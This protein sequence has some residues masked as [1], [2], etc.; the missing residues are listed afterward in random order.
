MRHNFIL[1]TKNYYSFC[2]EYFGRYIHHAP[3]I[4]NGDSKPDI[5]TKLSELY[6][7]IYDKLGEETLNHWFREVPKK[8]LNKV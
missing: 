5:E 4:G 3:V 8:Y 6:S 2:E 1:F 7:Y